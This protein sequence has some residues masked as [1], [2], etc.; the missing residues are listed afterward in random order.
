MAL[1]TTVATAPLTKLLYPP[2]YQK[3]LKQW[4][5][6]EIDWS[7]TPLNG[8]DDDA[9]NNRNVADSAQKLQDSSIRRLLVYLRIDSLPTIFT[10]ISL[11]GV[12]ETEDVVIAAAAPT[13][14]GQ[15]G[16]AT[17]LAAVSNNKKKKKKKEEKKRPLE[18]HG[19]RILE[20]TDRTSSVMQVTESGD[21][22]ELAA[23]RDPVVNAFKTFSRLHD[24]AVSGS[25]AV[26]PEDAYAQTVTAQ[27]VTQESDFVLV[28]W[29][30]AGK[31]TDDESV[32]AMLSS[33]S[34]QDRFAGRSHHEFVQGVLAGAVCNVGIFISNGFFSS[35]IAPGA[36]AGLEKGLER[37]EG[38]GLSR[39]ISGYSLRS[40]KEAAQPPVADKSH[41][42][43]LPFFVGGAADDR[44]ALRFV[45]QLA[46][47]PHITATIAQLSWGEPAEVA[48]QDSLMLAAVRGS[49][50][51]ALVERIS[52]VE[53]MVSHGTAVESALRLAREAVGQ[54]AHNAGDI[55]VVGR[56]HPKLQK[57]HTT[58]PSSSSKAAAT[59]A[60]A[61]GASGSTTTSN[62]ASENQDL[63]KTVGLLGEK[64]ALGGLKASVLV[65]Q[66]AGSNL[67]NN[68]Y[69]WF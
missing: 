12:E 67:N 63:G 44:A 21:H 65:I 3:K 38:G 24:V 58:S 7:G 47:T 32:P 61:A 42:V 20:L 14:P 13:T 28:P 52:F 68:N 15:D 18:V 37:M 40:H 55:I 22:V 66:A 49:L 5:H 11:L 50:P 33:S 46:R 56:R 59:T 29:S 4:K 10:F 17:K 64:M 35:G 23:R 31:H 60:S 27:A 6:G 25:V 1:V 54:N 48:T 2:W 8:P 16:D 41:H 45:L 43:F 51:A 69:K 62:I 39:S 53:A 9:N 30:E 34:S 36:S 26:A 57:H 19:L